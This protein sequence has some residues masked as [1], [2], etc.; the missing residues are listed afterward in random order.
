V[1]VGN[2]VLAAAVF[3]VTA[4]VTFTVIL[5]VG[6]LV[7]R[8]RAGAEPAPVRCTADGACVPAIDTPYVVV[9]R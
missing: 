4:I 6:W 7:G 9:R 5:V 1:N 2:W 3:A 8:Y